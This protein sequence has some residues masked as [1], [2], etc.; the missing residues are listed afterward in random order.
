MAHDVFICH[1]SVDKAI[2]DAVCAGLES[3]G[4]RCWIAPRDVT[5][6][7]AWDEA[8]V[9]AIEA[10]KVVVLVFSQHSNTSDQVT[11]EIR[12]AVA[13]GA[14]VIPF[15]L[16]DLPLS[17]ALKYHLAGSHWLDAITP[18]IQ[19]HITRLAE[20]IRRLIDAPVSDAVA[21]SAPAAAARPV[22]LRPGSQTAQVEPARTPLVAR[23]M[24]VTGVAVVA[25]L[26]ITIVVILAI[27][28]DP[29]RGF[30]GDRGNAGVP[31]ANTDSLLRDPSGNLVSQHPARADSAAHPGARLRVHPPGD[32][33]AEI[34]QMITAVQVL[35]TRRDYARARVTADEA[36]RQAQALARRFP[37]SDQVPVQR[38]RTAVDEVRT[39]CETERTAALGRGGTPPACF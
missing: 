8:I 25:G 12:T 7:L 20:T 6:G 9:E 1:S 26:A 31:Q 10:S 30:A 19:R 34:H 17:K 39:A 38:A 4:I 18:P 21:V 16:E 22:D 28:N 3:A 29:M 36:L 32:A 2:A 14:T 35:L 24:L 37:N 13:A 27:M 23:W 33:V 5:P 11:R 15:R